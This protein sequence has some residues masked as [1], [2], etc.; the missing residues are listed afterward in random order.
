MEISIEDFNALSNELSRRDVRIATLE[1]D[2]R[3]QEEKH[4]Y[5][6]KQMRDEC[7]ALLEENM[8]LERRVEMLLFL[9]IIKV[10]SA[11]CG[12]SSKWKASCDRINE[13][14]LLMDEGLEVKCDYN[15]LKASIGMK[16]ASLEYREWEE[17]EPKNSERLIF[18]KNKALA[19]LFEEELDKQLQ[20]AR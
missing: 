16:F 10:L 8:R 7:D 15:N 19:T 1:M 4:T 18:R 13:L 9:A 14:P 3:M 12:W 2:M 6:M 5:D 17:Y 20:V 11:K